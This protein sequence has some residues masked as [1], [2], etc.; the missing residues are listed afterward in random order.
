MDKVICN[1]ATTVFSPQSEA[2]LLPLVGMYRIINSTP[3]IPKGKKEIRGKEWYQRAGS[4]VDDT[5]RSTVKRTPR[6]LRLHQIRGH[7]YCPVVEGKIRF[8]FLILFV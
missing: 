3:T 4:G 1:F 7:L 5:K 2:L 8:C 6:S